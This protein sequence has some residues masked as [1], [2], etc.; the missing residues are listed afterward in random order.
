MMLAQ[1][2][3]Y[4]RSRYCLEVAASNLIV[5]MP[6]FAWRCASSWLYFFQDSFCASNAIAC[7]MR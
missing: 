7:Y 5:W 2:T 1:P 6:A 4:A 3:S